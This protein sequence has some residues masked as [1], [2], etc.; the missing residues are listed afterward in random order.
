MK[1]KL[2]SS[3]WDSFY[4][5]KEIS[6][7]RPKKQSVATTTGILIKIPGENQKEAQKKRQKTDLSPIPDWSDFLQ[8]LLH[9]LK[10]FFF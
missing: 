4:A 3:A 5:G 2:V 1:Q 7:A 9:E 6:I 10:I 8:E